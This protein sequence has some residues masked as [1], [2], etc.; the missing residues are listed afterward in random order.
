MLSFLKKQDAIISAEPVVREK[1]SYVDFIPYFHHYDRQTIETKNGE[2]LQI[3]KITQNLQGLN[4]EGH[5][6]SGRNLRDVIRKAITESVKTDHFSFWIHTIRKRRRIEFDSKHQIPFAEY[7]HNQWKQK[8]PWHYQYFNEVYLTVLREGQ[9]ADLS[10]INHFRHVFLPGIN[11]QFRNR[12]LEAMHRDLEQTTREILTVIRSEY[13]AHILGIVERMP[14]DVMPHITQPIFFSEPM[15]FLGGILNLS[16][17]QYPLPERDI[18][19]DINNH[20]LS[21]GYNALESKSAAGV[22]RFAGMITL[23][24]Y[25]EIPAETLDRVLQSSTEMI[26]S[27]SFAYVPYKEAAKKL[28]PQKELFDISGDSYSARA[29]GLEDSWHN[30]NRRAIDFGDEQTH[31][32]V[33]VDEYKQLEPEI[34]KTQDMFGELGLTTVREDMLLEDIFWSGLP[35]NFEFIRRKDM[36]S[37]RHVGGFARLNR[38]PTGSATGNHW[39][40]AVVVIP[41]Q[42]GSPYFFNFHHQD[43]GHTILFDYNSFRDSMGRVIVNFLMTEALKW[44]GR[45]IVFDTNKSARLWFDKI[46]RPYHH[47]EKTRPL[48]INPFTLEASPRNQ[49]FLLAWINELMGGRLTQNE[50]ERNLVRQAIERV[51]SSQ[52][53]NLATLTKEIEAENPALGRTLMQSLQSIDGCRFGETDDAEQNLQLAGFNMDALAKHPSHAVA[54]F[55][56]LLHRVV[57][58]LD[59][60]PTIIVIHDAVPLLENPFFAPR[61]ESLLEMLKQHNAML[62]LTV[63]NPEQ[64]T[65]THTL[66]TCMAHTATKLYVPDE[67]NLDYSSESLGLN[68]HDHTMLSRMSREDGHFLM[69]QGK[70]TINLVINLYGMYDVRAIMGNDIKN[71]ITAGGPYASLPKE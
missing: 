41:T 6:S 31:I 48:S 8:N 69:K 52:P 22:R 49:S 60:S 65:E 45:I 13:N 63:S 18:A 26:I 20:A 2:L 21:F 62:L 54:I 53:R 16:H 24:H 3:I 43:N 47:I 5:A 50:E 19:S 1:K 39:D 14:S 56:Y 36:I 55:A 46:D 57:S 7:V 11:R 32:L 59:G 25:H 28:K 17:E 67:I 15:E 44:Q 71:L 61:L 64:H 12:Y 35:G 33:V 66:K 4:Y 29:T 42:V 68:E 9:S 40:D 51:F 30:H 23:K 27:Q 34:I 70:E 58:E 37:S 10:N 38:F